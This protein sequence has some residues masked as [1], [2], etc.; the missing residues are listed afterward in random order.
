M[1]IAAASPS[2]SDYLHRVGANGRFWQ[3]LLPLGNNLCT[4]MCISIPC[5]DGIVL[6][7]FDLYRTHIVDS[8][9]RARGKQFQLMPASNGNS[10]NG[11]GN[12]CT[13]TTWLR[14]LLGANINFMFVNFFYFEHFFIRLFH[15]HLHKF[16]GVGKMPKKS[17]KKAREI[18]LNLS[19]VKAANENC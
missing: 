6:L 3:L 11:N 15:G 4:S 16:Q 5:T 14:I 7:C 13:N 2:I 19:S 8:L 12:T 10:G 9:R 1:N 18:A 17:G